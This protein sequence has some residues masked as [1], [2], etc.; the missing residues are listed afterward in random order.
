MN[1][2]SSEHVTQM[3]VNEE[4]GQE[5]LLRKSE[6]IP[7]IPH[8]DG[9]E[10]STLL[11]THNIFTQAHSLYLDSLV[12]KMFKKNSYWAN[13]V[14]RLF[15]KKNQQEE[16]VKPYE[17]DMK[18]DVPALQ[19]QDQAHNVAEELEKIWPSCLSLK[20]PSRM[21]VLLR[22]FL[23]MEFW[24]LAVSLSFSTLCTILSFVVP[25]LL[26]GF[27]ELLN[28]STSIG[29]TE[30]W[31][32]A[33][34][35]SIGMSFFSYIINSNLFIMAFKYGTVSSGRFTSAIRVKIFRNMIKHAD[36]HVC[37]TNPGQLINFITADCMSIQ[38]GVTSFIRFFPM[39]I[40]VIIISCTLFAMFG[41]SALISLGVIIMATISNSFT[42]KRIAK[43]VQTL[44][45]K[46][47]KR[48]GLISNI[49]E[50]IKAVKFF[51]WEDKFCEKTKQ[52][53]GEEISQ[54]RK[55][56]GFVAFQ[57][58]IGDT[59]ITAGTIVLFLFYV[60]FGNELSD[61]KAYGSLVLMSSVQEILIDMPHCI[62]G[63]I[64]CFTSLKRIGDYLGTEDV[65]SIDNYFEEEESLLDSSSDI[66]ISFN[67]SS[68]IWNE[69]ADE[70][71]VQTE[72]FK[73]SDITVDIPK[74]KLTVITGKVGSGKSSLLRAILGDMKQ[75]NGSLQRMKLSC[76][77]YSPQVPFIL[78]GTIVD[79]IVFGEEYNEERFNTVLKVCQLLTDIESMP[80]SIHT[81][82][83]ERGINLSGGQKARLSLARACYS[84]SSIILLD[85]VMAAVDSRVQRNILQECVLGFL[86]DRTIIL[87]CHMPNIIMQADFIISLGLGQIIFKGV[88]NEFQNISS[89]I[90]EEE[91]EQK[92]IQDGET[93][94]EEDSTVL[95]NEEND[96]KNEE[97]GKLTVKEE[98]TRSLLQSYIFYFKHLGILFCISLIIFTPISRALPVLSNW[99]LGKWIEAAKNNSDDFLPYTYIYIA[100]GVATCISSFIY[101]FGIYIGNVEA[102]R[103]MHERLIQ[104]VIYARM[105]FFD[106]NPSGRIINRFS[107]DII[108]IEDSGGFT[109]YFFT[110]GLFQ[111]LAI[112]IMLIVELPLFLIFIPFIP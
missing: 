110:V 69:S 33:C 75:T 46:R 86:K 43:L 40:A 70:K 98:T 20:Q 112:F 81:E 49:I 50:N 4:D 71:Q 51:V 28:I 76:I 22:A 6:E 36:T 30:F 54:M 25:F 62:E 56:N 57:D 66:A 83:G 52:V 19:E 41:W 53:R 8:N 32:W 34:F 29:E 91:E 47:D 78:S 27:I 87:T 45:E 64:S 44:M 77:A 9:N 12:W 48:I 109:L 15:R 106:K 93:L 95:V 7:E 17:L 14:K 67:N 21:P 103:R 26:M 79:N 96:Q 105:T 18:I 39:I 85:D 42:A 99:W 61:S 82:M 80:N 5:Q 89:N 16:E 84:T 65:R 90:I 68:F 37:T 97:K 3:I 11:E 94:K 58:F 102:V 59:F 23:K 1:S 13:K 38:R 92:T 72:P 63:V 2:S 10:G 104:C 55:I 111:T 100:L 35:Y 31:L 107:S 108:G 73:L 101:I 24:S 60:L 88:P 74:N